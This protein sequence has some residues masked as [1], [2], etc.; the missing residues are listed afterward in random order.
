MIKPSYPEKYLN[1]RREWT[2]IVSPYISVLQHNTAQHHVAK[3]Q[4]VAVEVMVLVVQSSTLKKLRGGTAAWQTH[5]TGGT[6]ARCP[7]RE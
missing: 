3:I 2:W 6:Y 7:E 4:A 5:S 1:Q